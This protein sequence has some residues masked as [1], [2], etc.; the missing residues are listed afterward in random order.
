[1]YF[2][3]PPTCILNSLYRNRLGL[4]SFRFTSY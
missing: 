2:W 1:M 4:P 3:E